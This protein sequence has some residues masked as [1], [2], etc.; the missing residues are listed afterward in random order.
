MIINNNNNYNKYVELYIKP[1][2]VKTL[3][4]DTIQ[5][6]QSETSEPTEMITKTNCPSINNTHIPS[7]IKYNKIYINNNNNNNTDTI[8]IA[9]TISTFFIIIIILYKFYLR[10]INNINKNKKNEYI[11]SFYD[12]FGTESKDILDF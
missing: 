7:S 10:Y 2:D 11:R 8:I 12:D 3:N 4:F 1:S 6:L 5:H 9:T